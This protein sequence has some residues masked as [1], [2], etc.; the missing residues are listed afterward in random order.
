MDKQDVFKA[1]LQT[2][3]ATLASGLE[4][5]VHS[6]S[7]AARQH[8]TKAMEAKPDNQMYWYATLANH[9]CPALHSSTPDEILANMQDEDIATLGI[10]IMQLSGLGNAG[11]KK[12]G[13]SKSDSS[14]A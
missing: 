11:K 1:S 8:F 10:K 7:A 3:T 4:L 14:T 6:L 12:S 9:C 2:G 13:A 5:E